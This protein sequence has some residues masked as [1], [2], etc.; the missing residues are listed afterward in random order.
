MSTSEASSIVISKAR[1]SWWTIR[2]ASKSPTLASRKSWKIVSPICRPPGHQVWWGLL[3]TRCVRSHARESPTSSFAPGFCLLDGPRGRQTGRVHE[4]G[5]HLERR[6]LD[7]RDAYRRA[8]LGSA[9]SD[10]SHLQGA[11]R[12][13]HCV[14]LDLPFSLD[15]VLT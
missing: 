12:A 11:S 2:V 9:Q 6:V 8:S 1:T 15:N 13:H 7:R 4:E 10:A 14:F 5:R 3:M